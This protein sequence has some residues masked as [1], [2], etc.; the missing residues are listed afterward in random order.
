M[1]IMD[2]VSRDLLIH[3][4]QNKKYDTIT[5]YA[6]IEYPDQ[7]DIVIT[8]Y[9]GKDIRAYKAESGEIR[10]L[11]PKEMTTV[12]ESALTQSIANGTIFDDAENVTNVSKHIEMSAIPHSGLVNSGH[13]VPAV[14][15]KMTAMVVGKMDDE[16][17]CQACD[18]DIENGEN[19]INDMV[20][21]DD[22][23]ATAREVVD[24][25]LGTDADEPVSKEMG[26]DLREV[27]E[28]VED[29]NEVTPEDSIDSSNYDVLD[30]NSG[31]WQDSPAEAAVDGDMS[32][33]EQSLTASMDE[34][35]STTEECGDACVTQEDGEP[36]S[37]PQSQPPSAPAVE[38]NDA[39]PPAPAAG[40]DEPMLDLISESE[41]QD[42]DVTKECGDLDKA[43]ESTVDWARLGKEFNL[44]FDAPEVELEKECGDAPT[45]VKECGDTPI[46]NVEECGDADVK[47]IEECGDNPDIVKEEDDEVGQLDFSSVKV[48]EECGENLYKTFEE[49]FISKRPKKLKPIPRSVVAYIQ[50]ELNNIQDANDQ[51]MLS[52]YTCSKM[53]LVDFYLNCLDTND[54]RYIV[55][56]NKQYL[57]TMSRDL[58]VL[59][60]QILRIKPINKAD[61]IWKANVTYPED[62]RG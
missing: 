54:D 59:L 44:N 6:N 18:A 22:C 37:Q 42:V 60:A 33:G 28:E 14:L 62:W 31:N 57:E 55:P 2:T 52:G 10:I 30:P 39:P 34:E 9:T 8:E 20:K 4:I 47:D 13:D 29:I 49:G 58:S 53:E 35:Q 7:S 40:G 11:C 56:H 1:N 16:G 41:D 51:A 45:D 23:N 17:R 19:F 46:S 36:Q 32:E 12:T 50:V 61:R 5:E 3:L 26:N 38:T 48:T 27:E 15:P 24:N 25:Y 21:K 43:E